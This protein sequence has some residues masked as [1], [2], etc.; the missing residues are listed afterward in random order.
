[1]RR[2]IVSTLFL[3]GT[4]GLFAQGIPF[5]RSFTS[6]DYHGHPMNLDV[7][8]GEKG[9]VFVANFEG[10]LYYDNV[11]WQILNTPNL[12]RVTV[13]YRDKQGD[14]WVGGYNYF[15]KVV[16]K[17][18]GT[19]AL[20]SYGTSSMFL[21]EVV[22]IWEDDEDSGVKFLIQNGTLYT[23]KNDKL[24]VSRKV[25]ND[26]TEFNLTD[27]LDVKKLSKSNQVSALSDT[28]V[29]EPLD[30]GLTAVVR[31]GR[32]LTICDDKG[33]ALF[34]IDESNGLKSNDIEYVSYDGHGTLWA[35]LEN[36]ICA[37]AIPSAFSHFSRLD[38]LT[39]EVKTAT[40]FN[41]KLYV[42]TLN[43]TFRLEGKQFIDTGIGHYACWQ[44][45]NTRQG[46][47]AA[48][49]TGIYRIHGDGSTRQLTQKSSISILETPEG[50]YS[51][52][53][54]GVYL[55]NPSDNSRRLVSKLENTTRIFQDRQGVIWLQ[56]VFGEIWN[57][58][59]GASGFRPY[60][61]TK[62]QTASVLVQVG[63][64]L[65]VIDSE[66]TS[67]IPYPLFSWRDEQGVTW[68]T[69]NNGTNLYRWKD[70]RRL[71]DLDYLYP[72]NELRITAMYQQGQELW[73]GNKEGFTVI[74][75]SAKDQAFQTKPRLVIRS[76]TLGNDS[77]IWGGFGEMPQELPLLDSHDRSLHFTYS[78]DYVPVVGV[79]LY[80]YQ[81][82]G[83][84][85]S[86]WSER[87]D[88]SFLNLPYGSYTLRVQGRNGFGHETDITSL[89]FSIDYPFYLKWYVIILYILLL[90]AF[91]YL[92][93]RLRLRSLKRDKALLEKTVK[94]RTAEI[95]KQKD[96]IQEKSE[97]LEKAL[98]DLHKAQNQLIRQEKMAT[99]GKL[100]QGLIDRI[101]NPLNYINNFSKLSEGLVKDIEANI[102]D[103]KEH[104]SEDNYEDT[105]EVLGMLKG[106]LQK[107][108]VHGQNTTRTLKAMEEM[109][110]DRTGGI[111]KMDITTIF[112]QNEEM[113]R[114]FFADQIARQQVNIK[115]TYPPDPVFVKGNPELLSK[116]FMSL[117]GNSMYALDKKGQQTTFQPE[118][119]LQASV[120][121][122]QITIRLRDNG[123][124]IEET[125]INKIFDPFFTTKTTGEA[126][127][128]GLYLSHDIIQNYG[129]TITVSSVKD[130]FT[131]FSMV[132][133][134]IIE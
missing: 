25:D 36:E 7:I 111:I 17:P 121:E 1:M 67:P 124:G 69:D 118:I 68:L 26:A 95:V 64:S 96:E 53:L 41:N 104:L 85:W 75:R 44:L 40:A 62:Q 131:E 103:E 52:E 90:L 48:T 21:G 16:R 28:I 91:L 82:N 61:K 76:V 50:I 113:V 119:T 74:D 34:T 59:P 73:L 42:G 23:V 49:A 6:D 32:G 123:I 11:R 116:V 79:T 120:S 134:V 37:I 133:P 97:S 46:L 35:V 54:D 81:L 108:G 117:L 109:L 132:L 92:L 57:K 78:L 29:S 39:A 14:I 15:G 102:E 20:K 65:K 125:I 60:E 66:D 56:N 87:Q 51:G 112:R 55:I 22:E 98:D 9:V 110:K 63:D 122:G 100:T 31:K 33:Q 99:V 83:G 130:E 77:V 89:N 58:V 19:L 18:N 129:G 27:V 106:N 107:V 12:A 24:S 128:T 30:N 80:R 45:L 93:V 126:S 70:G 13:A 47:L 38:G 88:V 94:E 84:S 86:A 71:D 72:F 101:L 115:F 5:M 8:T 10:L 127:G 4:C 43:G 3:L 105:I 114:Q 2:L